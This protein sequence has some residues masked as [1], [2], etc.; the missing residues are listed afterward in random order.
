ML[1]KFLITVRLAADID[2]YCVEI[3]HRLGLAR[4]VVMNHSGCYETVRHA[5]PTALRYLMPGF[6]KQGAPTLRAQVSVF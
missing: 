2:G 1:R 5:L 6:A 4:T 3:D